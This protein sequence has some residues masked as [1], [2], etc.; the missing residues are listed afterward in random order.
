MI[1]ISYA[2]GSGQFLCSNLGSLV[3]EFFEHNLQPDHLKTIGVEEYSLVV[4]LL[5]NIMADDQELVVDFVECA[6]VPKMLINL[7]KCNLEHQID[8]NPT[9]SMSS[10]ISN[11]FY[12]MANTKYVELFLDE[13]VEFVLL[14]FK[15]QS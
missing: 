8:L 2:S 6:N 14:V 7:F 13:L 12:V 3:L 9:T 10:D 15:N 4:N 1:N 5:S 11:C